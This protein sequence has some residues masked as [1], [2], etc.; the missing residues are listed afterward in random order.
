MH[1]VRSF[2]ERG[3]SAIVTGRMWEWNSV[4]KYNQ[5]EGTTTEQKY[6]Q[7]INQSVHGCS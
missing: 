2:I 7:Q 3:G 5:P 4:K 6:A 1:Q